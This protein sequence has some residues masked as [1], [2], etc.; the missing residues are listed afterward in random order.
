MALSIACCVN[1]LTKH[2]IY[3]GQP[4]KWQRRDDDGSRKPK[5]KPARLAKL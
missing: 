1:I 3:S 2:Y 5:E 4:P